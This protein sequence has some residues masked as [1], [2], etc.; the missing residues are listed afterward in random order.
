ME[1]IVVEVNKTT[2]KKWRTATPQE[3]R[4]IATALQQAVQQKT[5]EVNEPPLG[6]ARPSE[7]VLQAHYERVQK[8]FPEYCK[9]LDEIGKKAE[10]RGLTEEILEEILKDAS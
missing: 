7:E 2:A 8:S 3:K 4:K 10:E 6:Y 5:S 1:R 9:L